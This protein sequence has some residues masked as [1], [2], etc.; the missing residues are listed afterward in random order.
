MLF[1][2]FILCILIYNNQLDDSFES[3]DQN[4]F[5]NNLKQSAITNFDRMKF[6]DE[7]DINTKFIQN[8]S[9]IVYPDMYTIN[10]CCSE[11]QILNCAKYG[12]NGVCDYNKNNNE[13]LCQSSYM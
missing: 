10:N 12:K 1:I 7:S 5:T 13:C 2:L 3:F 6:V 11:N 8:P 9:D 4:N